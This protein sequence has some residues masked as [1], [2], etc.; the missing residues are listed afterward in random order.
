MRA[1]RLTAALAAAA[2]ASMTFAQA[3]S[4]QSPIDAALATK[5]LAGAHVGVLAVD[6]ASGAVLYARNPDDDFVPA[7]TLKLVV[8]SAAIARLGVSFRFTT[9]VASAGSIA[10]GTL[11]GDL[12]LRGGGDAQ[13]SLEDLD[14]AAAAVTAAG[15]RHV[16]GAVVGDATR[17]DAPRYP[18]GWSID[19]I[20][21][22]YAAVPS[23]LGLGLN[24]AH[25]RVRAGDALG[26]P[27]VVQASPQSSAFTIDNATVTGARGSADT[28]DLARPWDRPQTIRVFGS[29]PIGAPLSDDLEPAVPDPAAYAT[30]VFV[31]SLAA[32]GVTIDGGTRL[33]ATPAGATMLWMH[34]SKPLAGILRDF[35]PPSTN[36]IGEQ[37]LEELGAQAS[38]HAIAGGARGA[39]TRER[40]ISNET[41]WLASVGVDPATLTVVDGSGLSE[42]DRVTPCALVAILTADWR[43]PQRETV[44]A[45]LPIAGISGTL[46]ST[47]ARPPLQGAIYAKTGTTN[48]ARLLAGYARTQRGRTVIFALMVNDWM[49]A[50]GDAQKSLD[51]ARAA[52]LEALVRS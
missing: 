42:Y 48:H 40:G 35:W 43:G 46:R 51:A 19:D 29:Y 16:S 22:E 7:S 26:E 28:T 21:Y 10:N 12:Y 38:A 2:W 45:A 5:T 52:V 25:V 41:R 24:V 30:D 9:T 37:L 15:L 36:L 3:A 33:G 6:A 18:P 1:A 49:D 31:R 34:R 14:A 23:A 39:D 11:Q 32:R 50:S 4:P 27:T 13:L 47:F 17:Y 20:P 44:M 8:G